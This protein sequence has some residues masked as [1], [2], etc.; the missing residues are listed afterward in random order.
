MI[1]PNTKKNRM[2]Q[3]ACASLALENMYPDKEFIKELV[4]VQNGQKSL[5]D[6]I[7]KIKNKYVK[8]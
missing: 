5:D 4:R 8:Q 3:Q 7:Q 2:I 1:L 6:L